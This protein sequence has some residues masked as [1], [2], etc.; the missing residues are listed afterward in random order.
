M[1][2]ARDS[3]S[4]ETVL[5]GGTRESD[6][7]R[8]SSIIAFRSRQQCLLCTFGNRNLLPL[9]LESLSYHPVPCLTHRG[10]HNYERNQRVPTKWFWSLW[11]TELKGGKETG[12][13]RGNCWK[14]EWGVTAEA[15]LRALDPECPFWVWICLL[16]VGDNKISEV[17]GSLCLWVPKE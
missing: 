13:V 3:F 8:Q 14:L 12:T 5:W 4:V 1:L 15:V 7:G 16:P 17:W 6:H 11:S 9:V 10:T 2:F